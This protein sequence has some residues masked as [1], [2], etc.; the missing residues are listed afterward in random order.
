MHT[1]AQPIAPLLHLLLAC[2]LACGIAGAGEHG[3]SRQ[4]RHSLLPTCVKI[5]A[6]MSDVQALHL[7]DLIQVGRRDRCAAPSVTS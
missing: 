4:T 5:L 2:T 1:R 7:R 3:G 6:A